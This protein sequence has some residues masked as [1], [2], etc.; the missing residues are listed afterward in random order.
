[1]TPSLSYAWAKASVVPG[2]DV[3]NSTAWAPGLAGVWDATHDGRTALRASLSSYVDLD[4]GAIARHTIGTQAQQRC[5]WNP[6]TNAYDTGCVFSG[7]Q[8]KNT[9]GLPCG[10]LGKDAAGNDCRRDLDVPRTLEITAGGERELVPG[11]AAS[12][13]YVHRNYGHQYEINETNRI[14]N[15]SGTKLD[16]LGGYRNGKAETINDLG[17]PEGAQRRYDGVSVGVTK[18][19]GRVKTRISYTWSQLTGTVFNS[20]N[21]PWGDI[22]A[23]DAF[24]NGYLP[25]DHRHELKLTMSWEVTPWLT[26]G[27]R[28]TYMSGMPYDS[29]YRNDET[30]SYDQ[31]RAQRARTAGPNINDP[32]DDRDLRLPDQLEANVQARVNLKPFTGQQIDFYVD[33]LNSLAVR[34]VTAV[35]TSQG[36]DFGVSRAWM[37]PFRIRLGVNYRY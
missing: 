37:D 3:I 29:L 4:V 24:L 9:I 35:G 11:L 27:T 19:E 22:P 7:G 1:V 31:L 33:V 13:D 8:S 20:N 2:Q 30:A 32:S 36:Q 15:P 5:L 34:T 17:T 26:M 18:R 14:W 28:T 16:V 23:R 25:D 10:P 21:N 6:A 12:L